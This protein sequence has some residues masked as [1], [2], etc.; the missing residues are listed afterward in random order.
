[1]K[2]KKKREV[3][4]PFKYTTIILI[5]KKRYNNNTNNIHKNLNYTTSPFHSLVQQRKNQLTIVEKYLSI[6][7]LLD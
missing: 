3:I 6:T 4:T 5:K 2:K 7:Y 1:M